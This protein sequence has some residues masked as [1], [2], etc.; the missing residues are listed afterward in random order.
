MLMWGPNLCQS[1]PQLPKASGTPVWP[2]LGVSAGAV[3]ARR[4][5]AVTRGP[6]APRPRQLCYQPPDGCCWA[7]AVSQPRAGQGGPP[8]IIG[9]GHSALGLSFLPFFS[10]PSGKQYLSAYIML[11]SPERPA[12]SAADLN[13]LLRTEIGRAHV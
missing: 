10:L 4:D 9:D 7:M 13:P 1:P 8:F 12:A 11:A 5:T 3:L 2:V 6:G